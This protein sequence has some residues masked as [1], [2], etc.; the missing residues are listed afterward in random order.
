MRATLVRL[1]ELMTIP[2]QL[3]LFRI[4]VTFII[5]GLL[6]VPGVYAKSVCLAFFVL[7]AATDWWDGYLAR[8][9]GQVT[10]LGVLLDP[11]ADK[12]MVI[13]L[14]LALVQLGLV[15]AWMVLVIAFRE[16]LITGIR[17]YAANRQIVIPAAKEGKHKTVSQMLTL[18]VALV[19]LLIREFTRGPDAAQ[20]DVL[21]QDVILWCMWVTVVLTVYSG[22]MF[23]WRNRSV[24]RHV[25]R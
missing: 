1:R 22:A 15:R 19:L 4:I 8:R 25:S 6:F 12:V 18:T 14:L 2:N 24:L 20:F 10:P 3:C 16:F 23:F 11:I 5:M 17:L 21:T 9:Y 7:A 13:G